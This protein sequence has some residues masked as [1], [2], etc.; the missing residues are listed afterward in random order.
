MYKVKKK[1]RQE[2]FISIDKKQGVLEPACDGALQDKKCFL[3]VSN[4]T[5]RLENLANRDIFKVYPVQH[6]HT[7]FVLL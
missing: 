5:L 3:S 6:C 2:A 7:P 1:E 4:C